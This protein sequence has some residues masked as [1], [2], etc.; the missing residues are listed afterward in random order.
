MRPMKY[1]CYYFE[2]MDER[3]TERVREREKKNLNDYQSSD[4]ST[5]F[6]VAAKLALL[7][8][9][10]M[11]LDRYMRVKFFSDINSIDMYFS[12]TE[13]FICSLV[14]S[15]NYYTHHH[16]IYLKKP[17]VYLMNLK[18][19]YK[20]IIQRK[21][22]AYSMEKLSPYAPF[23]ACYSNKSITNAVHILYFLSIISKF[24]IICKWIANF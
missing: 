11:T 8:K 22:Y 13:R 19:C 14:I 17:L 15:C 1:I 2:N 18:K 5:W 3:K 24:C 9:F 10:S 12:K 23:I 7:N 21:Y 20:A 4:C 16:V 6:L